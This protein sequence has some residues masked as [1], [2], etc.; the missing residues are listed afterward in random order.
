MIDNRRHIEPI[1]I[2]LSRTNVWFIDYRTV[3]L[4]VWLIVSHRTHW[5]SLPGTSWSSRCWARS[6]G[7]GGTASSSGVCQRRWIPRTDPGPWLRAGADPGGTAGTARSSRCPVVVA[8]RTGTCVVPIRSGSGPAP[9]TCSGSGGSWRGSWSRCCCELQPCW[10][11]ASRTRTDTPVH[12]HKLSH[13][14]LSLRCIQV[15]AGMEEL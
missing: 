10:S 15:T 1:N 13:L 7:P 11:C 6:P 5:A 9:G 3:S 12:K 2:F 14:P 8:G 4:L